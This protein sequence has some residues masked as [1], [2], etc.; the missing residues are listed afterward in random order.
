MV[1]E[2]GQLIAPKCT[3]MHKIEYLFFKKFPGVTPPDP[4][5]RGGSG[6]VRGNIWSAP[7]GK[8]PAGAHGADHCVLCLLPMR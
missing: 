7:L 8:Y 6:K 3:K 2:G 1:R 5:F 4:L